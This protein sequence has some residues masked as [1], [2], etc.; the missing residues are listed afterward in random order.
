LCSNESTEQTI[1]GSYILPKLRDVF[2]R[3]VA[4]VAATTVMAAIAGGL[5]APGTAAAATSIEYVNYLRVLDTNKCLAYDDTRVFVARCG[6]AG[7]KWLLDDVV[8]LDY[9]L[10]THDGFRCL[11]PD[12][13]SIVLKNCDAYRSYQRWTII[14]HGDANWGSISNDSGGYLNYDYADGVFMTSGHG[15]AVTD[16]EWVPADGLE[17]RGPERPQASVVGT[18]IPPVRHTVYMGD[19]GYAWSATGLPPGLS[20][21]S[22]TGTISGTPTTPG[23]FTVQVTAIE[24]RELPRSGSKSYRWTVLAVPTPGCTGTNDTDVAIPDGTAIVPMESY[25]AITGCPGNVSSVAAAEVHIKHPWIGN[26]RVSLVD[27]NGREYFLQQEVGGSN[28]DIDKTYP[29]HL[30]NP[31][32]ADGV[33]RLRVADKAADGNAG[34]I[35]SWTLNL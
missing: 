21:D 33:W 31:P 1:K 15:V 8:G 2:G 23:S 12:L 4:I 32:A 28:E 20:I 26:L 16:W 13:H 7:T 25:I 24:Y 5:S 10:E 19:G 3:R 30:P 27:P 35:D 29:L 34:L 18:A 6:S 14:S 22:E 17:V 11:E 9:R